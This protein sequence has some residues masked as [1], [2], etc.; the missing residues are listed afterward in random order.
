MML[1]LD[2][3]RAPWNRGVAIN[4]SRELQKE[5]FETMYHD[6]LRNRR[7]LVLNL[8]PWLIGQPVRI[9]HLEEAIGYIM[10]RQ[11]VWAAA[12]EEI[13]DWFQHNLPAARRFPW[14][15][16]GRI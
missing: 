4:R 1:E 7:M 11:G 14:P 6:G 8:H 15:K 12:G 16:Q 2:D 3:T 9:R 13:V 10:R 5:G